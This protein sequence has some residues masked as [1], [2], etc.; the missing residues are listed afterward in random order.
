MKCIWTIREEIFPTEEQKQKIL[1]TLGCCRFVYNYMLSRNRKA[2]GRRKAKV[3]SR[4]EMQNLLPK[5]KQVYPWLKD[6]DSQA[7][8]H[9]CQRLSEAYKRFFK[10]KKGYPKFR[11]RKHPVQ[12]YTTNGLYNRHITKQTIQLPLLGKVR[13]ALKRDVASVKVSPTI[14]YEDGRF[15]VSV[16]VEEERNVSLVAAADNEKAVG[17]DY[18]SNSLYV[19]SNGKCADMP[20]YYRKAQRRLKRVQKKMSRQI[21][22]HIV[23][24]GTKRRPVYD[25]KLS[26]CKNVQKQRKKLAKLSCH[27]ANQRKDFLHKQSTAIAKQYDVVCVENLNMQS[28][29]NKGFGN[30]KATLDNGYGMFLTF[31][32][33]KLEERGK[34]LVK[35]DK[36]FPSSQLCSN[37]GF[38]NEEIKD[39]RIRHWTCPH[40][41]EELDRDINAA[42]NIR[43]EGLRILFEQQKVA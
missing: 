20:H 1:Q 21:E 25:C 39:L 12:S 14:R 15:F 30:G 8:Q 33:Y 31:L 42:I 17:L 5:L 34:Y 7:L 6:A 36:F 32:Q 37:C 4:Y 43:N 16:V 26:D 24:H 35:V 3:M 22:G 13:W 18:K 11:S 2:Y 9:S 10:T 38:R 23:G 41:G 27:V 40:C 29:A 19:D 28:L